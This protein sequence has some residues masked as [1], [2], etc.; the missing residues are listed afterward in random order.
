MNT[1]GGKKRRQ[2]N[3]P[4]RVKFK[5]H[6][7]ARQTNTAM[8]TSPTVGSGGGGGGGGSGGGS[9]GSRRDGRYST[10]SPS[11]PS[12]VSKQFQVSPAKTRARTVSTV[13]SSPSVTLPWD[14]SRAAAAISPSLALPMGRE[15]SSSMASPP[16]PLSVPQHQKEVDFRTQQ[17]Q[18]QYTPVAVNGPDGVPVMALRAHDGSLVQAFVTPSGSVVPAKDGSNEVV[19][20]TAPSRL[21]LHAYGGAVPRYRPEHR[22][23]DGWGGDRELAKQSYFEAQAQ[24]AENRLRDEEDLGRGRGG[25]GGGGGGEGRQPYLGAPQTPVRHGRRSPGRGGRSSSISNLK[26]LNRTAELAKAAHEAYFANQQAAARYQQRHK[27]ER[28]GNAAA[29]AALC[30]DQPYSPSQGQG[31]GSRAGPRT[32]SHQQQPPS[33]RQ[34][35]YGDNDGLTPA[36]RARARKA[37]AR[38]TMIQEQQAA[39]E[40][41]RKQSYMDKQEIKR[42]HG[43]VVQKPAQKG[44]ASPTNPNRTV[45]KRWGSRTESASPSRPTIGT[46][47]IA[48]VD[49]PR[50]GGG[51]GPDLSLTR[52]ISKSDSLVASNDIAALERE[53]R[54]DVERL[55]DATKSARKSGRRGAAPS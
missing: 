9:G 25:G 49:Q 44:K 17:Q 33:S 51:V 7:G 39:L 21:G 6:P 2:W 32:T 47:T 42:K 16:P 13:S 4:E 48:S 55:V 43:T 31:R 11:P 19:L 26:D 53:I 8:V 22:V 10:D 24:A 23:S 37:R 27:D 41:A 12:P 50:G 28:N 52:T 40:R 3:K 30:M 34:P 54:K 35:S 18:Q 14:H 1:P 36:E 46:P 5:K 20:L 29:A 38:E 45:P 15:S